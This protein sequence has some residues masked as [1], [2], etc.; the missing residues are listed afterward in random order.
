MNKA[1]QE[2]FRCLP[3]MFQGLRL[4]WNAARGWTVAWGILLLLQGLVPAV[5]VYL[6]RLVVNRLSTALAG[7]VA[8]AAFSDVWIRPC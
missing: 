3:L 6:T 1:L 4:V 7:Q 5:L 8:L 2:F